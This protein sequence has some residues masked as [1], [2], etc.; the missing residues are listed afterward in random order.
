MMVKETRIVFSL[1]D[2]RQVRMVCAKC[3]GE[4]ARP[5]S[6]SVHMLPKQC[7]NCLIEWWDGL[8]KPRVIE[9]T[10]DMLKSLDRLQRALG[11]D[12]QPISIRFELDDGRGE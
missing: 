9:A 1:D 8:V 4:I 7:P 3:Q 2:I 5:L 10:V 12:D 11:M 6:Q